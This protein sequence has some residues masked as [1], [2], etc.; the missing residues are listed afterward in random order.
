MFDNGYE[1]TLVSRFF[2]KGNNLHYE[3]T[4]Y[5]LAG[6]GGTATIYDAGEDL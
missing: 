6:V 5:T 2:T 3:D 4:T 1:L